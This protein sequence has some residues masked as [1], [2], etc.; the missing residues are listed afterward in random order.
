MGIFELLKGKIYTSQTT[1]QAYSCVCKS[2]QMSGMIVLVLLQTELGESKAGY[3]N[4]PIVIRLT[5]IYVILLSRHFS[6]VYNQQCRVT[7]NRVHYTRQLE[8]TKSQYLVW[9]ITL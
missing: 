4:E 5:H 9:A 6:N 7:G 3:T 8:Y 2:K 1:L